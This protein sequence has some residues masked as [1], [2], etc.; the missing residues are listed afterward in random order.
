MRI[1]SLLASATEI[2]CALGLADNLVGISHGCDYPT[3]IQDR[4]RLTRSRLR[5]DLPSE[6]IHQEVHDGAARGQSL[7]ELAKRENFT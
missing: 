2:L 5:P 3:E 6:A 4:P 7:Y 1:V